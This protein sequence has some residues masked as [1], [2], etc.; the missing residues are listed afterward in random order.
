MIETNEAIH[1]RFRA[2]KP[3]VIGN[4]QAMRIQ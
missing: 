3:S 4:R 2:I 1:L